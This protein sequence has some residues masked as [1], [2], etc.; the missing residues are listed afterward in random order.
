MNNRASPDRTLSRSTDWH[1]DAMQKRI[2]KRY[3]A[4]RRFKYTGFAAVLISSAFLAFLLFVMVGNGLRGFQKTEISLPVDF[5]AATGGASAESLRGENAER[6]AASLDLQGVINTAIDIEYGADAELLFTDSTWTD[7]R[8][9]LLANPDL[10]TRKAAIWITASP[11]IDRAAKADGN[12]AAEILYARLKDAGKA[13]TSFNWGFLTNA[14]GTDPARVGIWGALKGSIITMLVTLALAFP[15]GV[16]AAVY[17]EEYAPSNRLTDLIEVSINNLAAVPSIIFGLLGLVVFLS[18]MELPRSSALVGGLTLALMTMPVIVIAGR[19]A[20]KSVPPSIREAALGVGSS[21][22]QVVFHHVLPLALPGIMTGTIIGMARALG[23][24]APLL[25]IGMRA[26]LTSPPQ[27]LSDPSTVLPV[28]IYLWSDEV[29]RGFV[30]KTSA[31]IIIL[32]LFLLT[33]NAFAIY[34]RNRFETRW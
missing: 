25:M 16:L 20:I 33:M 19:N 13:R 4:E 6:A 31:A 11:E 30:E 5:V 8:D 17:L 28:Q 32:L 21:P 14:D 29:N 23:E 18:W 12:A 34:L 9:Q 2:A 27:G 7:A 10:V 24:T 15:V 3:A 22:I 26:F 1:G